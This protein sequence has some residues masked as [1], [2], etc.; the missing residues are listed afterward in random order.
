MKILIVGDVCGK[1]GRE[2]F[3]K[4]IPQLKKEHNI[5]IVMVNGENIAGGRGIQS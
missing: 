2:T 1:P 5:D 4:Y 3:R